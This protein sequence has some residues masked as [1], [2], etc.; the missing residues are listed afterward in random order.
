[1]AARR[2]LF[3]LLPAA[4][5]LLVV[6]S[7]QAQSPAAADD[8]TRPSYSRMLNIDAL[9]ENHARFLA[10]RYN[11]SA[12]Q[13]AFTQAFLRQKTQEFLARHREEL[14]DLVDRL[15]DVRAGAEM[16]QQ[17]LMA[18]GKRALPLYEEAKTLIV[19]GNQEWRGIL[20]EEQRRTHDEDLAE[21]QDSFAMTESQLQRI[22]SGEMTVEEFRKGPAQPAARSAPR[23]P[24]PKPTPVAAS[25]E[26]PPPPPAQPATPANRPT[27]IAAAPQ[28]GRSGSTGRVGQGAAVARAPDQR[29]SRGRP[30]A[31]GAV[32][33]IGFESQWEAYVRDF[34][35]RYQLDEGQTQRAQGIL[36][37]CQE[38]ANRLIQ[39]RKPELERLD[40]QLQE[41][42]QSSDAD[43]LKQLSEL[44]QKRTKL[45]EP[46]NEI[47]EK[48]LKPRLER[49]P[50]RAQRQAAEQGQ[51][52]TPAGPAKPL[53]PTPQ[54]APQQPPP[55]Q[56][57][58][59]QQEPLP[60]QPPEEQPSPDAAEPP[61]PPPPP[62]STG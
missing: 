4:L 45:F 55:P 56:P 38:M 46:V 40:R 24:T 43:K 49:L 37:D 10:R 52:G 54:P 53:R 23:P 61:P 27:P 30:T 2:F 34:I 58:P 35:Q 1:M 15:V 14:F 16:T 25:P 28:E 22:V 51:R 17:D 21:M 13:D 29:G 19:S 12:D 20:T 42:G 50:T 44:N 57:M 33:G 31:V 9:L 41:L 32:S 60:P 7:A 62:E 48:Q 18:W 8:A 47:F 5:F 3:A 39:K 11:L 59:P 36:K 6:T 26:P